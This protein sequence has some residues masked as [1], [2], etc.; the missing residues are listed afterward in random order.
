MIQETGGRLVLVKAKS[1]R[2]RVAGADTRAALFCSGDD[3]V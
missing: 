3:P 2:F 1:A